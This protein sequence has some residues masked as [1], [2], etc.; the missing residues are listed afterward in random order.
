MSTAR[1]RS[2]ARTPSD[3]RHVGL[4]LPRSVKQ[5][6]VEAATVMD[7]SVGDWVLAIAADHGPQLATA[8]D[9]R[10]VRKR[11][12]VPD[13]AFTALYLTPEE[14]AELDDQ[15]VACR[16][17]RSAFVTA[18]AQLGLGEDVDAVVAALLTA[19]E[20]QC[21]PPGRD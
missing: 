12:S 18:V 11:S 17:N 20:P 7:W 21:A 5:R 3:R 14:K 15:A 1:S 10:E 8:L 2:G 13:A 6:V 4:T 16:L 19:A 9:G